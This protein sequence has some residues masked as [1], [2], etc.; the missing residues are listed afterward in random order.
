[1]QYSSDGT[2]GVFFFGM[3]DYLSM[4]YG[5]CISYDLMLEALKSENPESFTKLS[6]SHLVAR[7]F[8]TAAPALA[9][10]NM[11]L[12]LSA[13]M[14]K[15]SRGLWIIFGVLSVCCLVF[16]AMTFM[17]FNDRMCKPTTYGDTLESVNKTAESITIETAE[18]KTI[19]VKCFIDEGSK[20]AIAAMSLY[21]VA[22]VS[23][24]KTPAPK[25]PLF[26]CHSGSNVDEQDK[27]RQEPSAFQNPQTLPPK[28]PMRSIYTA[29]QQ[30]SPNASAMDSS[31]PPEEAYGR[32]VITTTMNPDGTRTTHI[33]SCTPAPSAERSQPYE[34]SLN[35]LEV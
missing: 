2:I 26:D 18:L 32:K 1:M 22:A 25:K 30:M 17:V 5:V 13:L 10:V 7:A 8:A 29:T 27:R 11:L 21:L 34:K 33:S 31:A 3:Y 16:Q 35:E 19:P 24:F 23:I 15:T 6:T 9:G 20:L 28:Q 14:R 12:V 4:D